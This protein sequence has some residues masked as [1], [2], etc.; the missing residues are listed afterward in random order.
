MVWYREIIFHNTIQVYKYTKRCYYLKTA[1]CLHV[2][3][4]VL[5]KKIGRNQNWNWKLSLLIIDIY[6]DDSKYDFDYSIKNN[7]FTTPLSYS[8]L[9]F[10]SSISYPYISSIS[11]SYISFISYLG[12]LASL[13]LTV[14][15][16][17]S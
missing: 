8:I 15:S 3:V 13:Y 5:F 12:Y 2:Y 6:D 7:L 17:I 4:S 11:Y 10:T 1:L 9:H 16:K 14:S